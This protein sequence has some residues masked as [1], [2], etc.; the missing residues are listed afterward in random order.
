MAMQTRIK[1]RFDPL[2]SWNQNDIVLLRGEL[3]VVDCGSQIRFKIG[4]GTKRFTQL[5]FVDQS[6]LCTH[7]IA[8]D[9]ISQGL[10]AKSVPYGFAAGAYLCAN[11]NFSQALGFDAQTISSDTYS[12]VWNG[13]DTRAVGDYYTSHGKGSF[14][15]NPLSGLS[16]FYVGEKNLASVLSTKADAAGEDTWSIWRT[17]ISGNSIEF[18]GFESKGLYAGYGGYGTVHSSS[19]VS[20]NGYGLALQF[21]GI[22][23]WMVFDGYAYGSGAYQPMCQTSGDNDASSLTFII[24]DDTYKLPQGSYTLTKISSTT[25]RVAYDYEVPKFLG[26]LNNDVGYL[27]EKAARSFVGDIN[28]ELLAE[29]VPAIFRNVQLVKPIQPEGHRLHLHSDIAR[30]DQFEDMVAAGIDTADGSN[31]QFVKYFVSDGDSGTWET[32]TSAG[33]YTDADEIPASFYLADALHALGETPKISSQYFLRYYWYYDLSGAVHKSDQFSIAIPSNTAAGANPGDVIHKDEFYD[34]KQTVQPLKKTVGIETDYN[35]YYVCKPMVVSE[36]STVLTGQFDVLLDDYEASQIYRFQFTVGAS[37]ATPTFYVDYGNGPEVADTLKVNTDS[38]IFK[39]GKSYYVELQ[40]DVLRVDTLG[41]AESGSDVVVDQVL[42]SGTK[43]ATISVDGSPT[44]IYAPNPGSNVSV[45]AILT[46]GTQIASISVG[47][48]S[49][50]LYAPT[51]GGGTPT[52]PYRYPLITAQ[53]TSVGGS[54]CC[55]IEDHAVTTI[56]V[57]S[58]STP[59]I[60]KLPPKP[61]GNGSRDF[62]LRIEVS[63]STAPGITFAGLDESITFDS[64]SDDWMTI[65]P[66]LNLISFTETR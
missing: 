35:Q 33:L 59:L 52:E 32:M 22:S 63:S 44:D 26:Q 50:D 51:G 11:A 13:D 25:G 20:Y 24:S 18:G 58:A 66:G 56:E 57:S 16:G 28:D 1:Q 60:V 4:D 36:I 27:T 9:A 54:L 61:A 43:I 41:Y 53:L 65:E 23:T 10:H 42:D 46:T 15:I 40:G 64:D 14:S 21:D 55:L 3:A 31:Y 48:Q 29:I 62:I 17:V 8:A 7:W 2:S 30:D 38:Y 6:Q 12:F 34:L 39:A 5:P 19:P 49:Y 47:N 37:D 45:D